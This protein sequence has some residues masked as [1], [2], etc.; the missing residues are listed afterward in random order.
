VSGYVIFFWNVETLKDNT[1]TSFSSLAVSLS[2]FLYHYKLPVLWDIA[3]KTI[4]ASIFCREE[5]EKATQ[6]NNKGM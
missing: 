2:V 3:L 4:I 5:R 1:E 6:S